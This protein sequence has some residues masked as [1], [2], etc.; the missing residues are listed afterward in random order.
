MFDQRFLTSKV[1]LAALV[2]VAAMVAFNLY[3]LGQQASFSLHAEA[4][5]L[6]VVSPIVSLA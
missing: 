2:S 5:M 6:L 4:G 3:A 1:G